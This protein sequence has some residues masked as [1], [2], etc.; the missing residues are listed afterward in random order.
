VAARVAAEEGVPR[1][2]GEGGYFGQA[3]ALTYLVRPGSNKPRPF[4]QL[5]QVTA[6]KGKGQIFVTGNVRALLDTKALAAVSWIKEGTQQ[7]LLGRALR[8]DVAKLGVEYDVHFHLPP[9]CETVH[10]GYITSSLFM[11]MVSL[12]TGW[13]MHPRVRIVN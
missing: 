2:L 7:D 10:E 5:V 11:A 3:R 12:V 9:F 4:R 6:I 13:Q 1:V 8:L